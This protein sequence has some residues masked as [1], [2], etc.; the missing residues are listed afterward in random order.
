MSFCGNVLELVEKNQVLD[1]Y[2]E[3]VQWNDF[4]KDYDLEVYMEK[5]IIPELEEKGLIIIDAILSKI[6]DKEVGFLFMKKL[7]NNTYG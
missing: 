4:E 7:N 1:G 5:T 6:K 2:P 3:F